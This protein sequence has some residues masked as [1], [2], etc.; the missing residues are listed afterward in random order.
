MCDLRPVCRGRPAVPRSVTPSDSWSPSQPEGNWVIRTRTGN[1]V[2]V[3]PAVVV[4]AKIVPDAPARL[5]SAREIDIATLERIAAKA[6]QPLERGCA[7]RMDASRRRPASPAGP[8][9]SFR[10]AIPGEPLDEALAQV[11]RWY[12]DR[13]LPAMIQVPLPLRADLDTALAERGWE[14]TTRSASWSATLIHC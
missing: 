1:A 3:D 13:S 10:L 14:P 6:W 9:A 2:T 12:A 5:R 8:T 11:A 4:A 7:G